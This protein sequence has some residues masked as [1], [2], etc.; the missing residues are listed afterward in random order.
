MRD[1]TL[2]NTNVMAVMRA[3]RTRGR[4]EK[5][6]FQ[7][8]KTAGDTFEHNYGHGDTHLANVLSSLCMLALRLDRMT[9]HG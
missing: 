9:E 7:T 1:L 6:T 8:L 4:I 5:E 3:G 2:D